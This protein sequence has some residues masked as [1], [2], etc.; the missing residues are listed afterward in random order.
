MG[1]PPSGVTVSSC[2]A[3]ST[4]ATVSGLMAS[5]VPGAA[6]CGLSARRLS[7]TLI[8]L[9]SCANHATGQGFMPRTQLWMW[10]ALSVKANCAAAL[11]SGGASVAAAWFCAMGVSSPLPSLSTA[12]T[13][14]AAPMA[15]TLSNSSPLVS[16]GSM[17]TG[18]I[19][20]MS[21]VSSP[22]S[23][24]MMVTPVSAS[25]LSTAHWMGAEPRYFGSWDTCRLMHPYFARCRSWGGM[26]QP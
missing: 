6:P 5:T 10:A 24:C 11:S 16:S 19:I 1:L 26:M 21:P 3:P 23:S 18:R 4:A 9:P 20:R 7:N 17:A 22:S 2:T 12:S 25:P 8:F 13:S 14:V 15:L